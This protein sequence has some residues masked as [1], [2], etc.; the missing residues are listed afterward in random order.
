VKAQFTGGNRRRQSS[1]VV[2]RAPRTSLSC[3]E[4]VFRLEGGT[5]MKTPASLGGHPIHAI[6]VAIPIGL[7]IFALVADIAAAATGNP[8]WLTVAFY[9]M[10]GGVAGALLAAIPGLIDLL[11][12]R[13]SAAARTG[14]IHMSANL[15]AVAV[16]AVNFFMRWGPDDHHGPLLLT[17]LGVAII[18]FSGWLGGQLV[19]EHG[20]GVE[21]VPL[22]D[23]SAVARRA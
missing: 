11:S 2:T 19:Y 23:E 3:I 1:G 21:G 18:G 6:L 9:T 13:G 16:F 12:L 7:W 4:T 20:V 15:L 5:A 8:Q 17:L 10:G 22:R 14:I